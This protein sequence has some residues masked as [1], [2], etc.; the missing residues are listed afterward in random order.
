V[1]FD[2]VKLFENKHF[3][4]TTEIRGKYAMVQK[5]KRDQSP[6]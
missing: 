1:T 5:I 4:I 3:L 6:I 2:P